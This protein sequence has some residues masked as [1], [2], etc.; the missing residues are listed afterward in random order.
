MT[1]PHQ[2]TRPSSPGVIR[3][4]SVLGIAAALALLAAPLVA[5]P[6][7]VAPSPALAAMPRAAAPLPAQS[8]LDLPAKDVSLT[9]DF[10][11][12]RRIGG[13]DALFT[14][15]VAGHFG[16]DG[17]LYV[18]D[19]GLD[20]ASRLLA[21]WED[22]TVHEIGRPGQGPGEFTGLGHVAPISGGRVAAFDVFHGAYQIFGRDGTFERLVKMGDGEAAAG[23]AMLAHVGRS[24]R[25]GRRGDDLISVREV[26]LDVSRIEEGEMRTSAGA[27]LE[28]I[29]LDGEVA[30]ADTM[31]AVWRPP[32]GNES[33]VEMGGMSV[34][35]AR[36]FAPQVRYD[37]AADGT[38]VFSDSTAYAIKVVSAG[39]E[40]DMILR[41][42]FEAIPV[43]RRIRQRTREA[44]RERLEEEAA[45]GGLRA[46]MMAQMRQMLEDQIDD[47]RFYEEIS[48]V[49]QV[50]AGWGD[51]IWVERTSEDTPWDEDA[52]G[53][54]DV[55]TRDGRYAGTF[56]AEDEALPLALGPDGLAAYVEIDALDQPTLALKRLPPELR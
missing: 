45:T 24:A 44:M 53:L 6:P 32:P 23:M 2:S 14:D 20:L 48:A 33:E 21:V 19:Q 52:R 42:P 3:A 47:M 18:I 7:S 4:A 31:L 28:R 12:V 34:S 5:E 39:G 38:I 35:V 56:A 22:G 51:A 49:R 25:P 11:E 37:V 27:V 26:V 10:E 54:V 13:S 55:L 9:F 50:K 40:V 1:M 16:D 36:T 8:T 17:T 46:E 30:T 43:N 15:I 41:R 29:G